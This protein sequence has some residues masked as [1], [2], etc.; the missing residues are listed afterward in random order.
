MTT[1]IKRPDYVRQRLPEIGFWFVDVPRTSSTVL[2]MAFYRRY[3]R[4]FGK[5]SASSGIGLGLIP[6]HVPAAQLREALGPDLWDSL[7]TFSIVR[8]PFE[9]VLSLFSF[10]QQNGKLPGMS[11]SQYVKRLTRREF[12]YHGHYLSNTGY[13]CD[14]QGEVLVSEV[15]RYDRR[16]EWLP[17]IAERTGCP[18]LMKDHSKVYSTGSDSGL[19]RFDTRSRRL[20]RKFFAEDFERFDFD[21]SGT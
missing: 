15:F 13:V 10:L 6:P 19:D 17:V 21:R 8:N 3:G 1:E 20:I 16:P 2:R 9:R 4:L 12:D 5:P 14:D 7:Y 18:E 11:L